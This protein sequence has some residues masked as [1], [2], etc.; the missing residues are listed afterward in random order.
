MIDK[1]VKKNIL[2]LKPYTSARGSYLEGIL[3]DANENSL[4]SVF[5]DE[6]K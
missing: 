1:L 4:G 6:N 5:K 2:K 3:M